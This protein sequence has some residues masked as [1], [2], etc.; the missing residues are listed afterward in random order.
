MIAGRRADAPCVLLV[1]HRDEVFARLA[2][3]LAAAGLHVIRATTA[4]EAFYHAVGREPRLLI[5]NRDLPGQSA[6]LL[7]ARLRYIAPAIRI[8]IYQPWKSA[9]SVAMGNMLGVDALLQYGGDLF[10]LS[11]AILDSLAGCPTFT[12]EG[13]EMPVT[14][15]YAVQPCP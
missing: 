7:A 2:D 4:L 12:A 11:D 5:A 1:E 3:D 6:W 13:L 15:G 10:R 14:A 9:L 8:W